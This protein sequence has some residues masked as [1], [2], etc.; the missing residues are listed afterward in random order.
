MKYYG[1]AYYPE[2]ETPAQI[3]R[4]IAD[5]DIYFPFNYRQE[6]TAV[7]FDR[8]LRNALTGQPMQGFVQ[9]APKEYLVLL[10][11]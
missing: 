9:L 8:P 4:D 2:Q 5:E 1:A 6:A 11:R 7:Q 3:E 10:D